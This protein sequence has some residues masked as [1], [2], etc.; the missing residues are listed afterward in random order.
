MM[1]AFCN[2]TISAQFLP[3]KCRFMVMK[4]IAT[5][6]MSVTIFSLMNLP[7]EETFVGKFK[8]L[9][10]RKLALPLNG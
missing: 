7:T 10:E 9:I 3:V 1:T 8:M 6:V 5:T 2:V 4:I